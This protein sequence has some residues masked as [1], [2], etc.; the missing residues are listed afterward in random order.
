MPLC[1]ALTSCSPLLFGISPE[2]SPSTIESI[3]N[4]YRRASPIV[5]TLEVPSKDFSLIKATN[6]ANEK[7]YGD[8]AGRIFSIGQTFAAYLEQIQEAAFTLP[9]KETAVRFTA[10]LVS[11]DLSYTFK[12]GLLESSVDWVDLSLTVFTIDADGNLL[13]LTIRRE[14]SVPLKVSVNRDYALQR[15]IEQLVLDYLDTILRTSFAQ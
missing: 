15:V 8:R 2:L 1:I 3:K 10:R 5:V 11:A 6:D 14:V 13:P 7:W 4:R 12:S 9:Q